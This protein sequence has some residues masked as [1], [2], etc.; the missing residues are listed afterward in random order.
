MT[1]DQVLWRPLIRT[2][3]RQMEGVRN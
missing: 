3:R 2:H 1:N